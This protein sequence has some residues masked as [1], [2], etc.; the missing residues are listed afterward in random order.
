MMRLVV[1]DKGE[2]WPDVL[3]KAP[4][5]GSYLCMQAACL[6]KALQGNGNALRPLSRAFPNLRA[7]QPLAERLRQAIE[8][9]TTRHL[10][11]LLP[12][13]AIGRDA[14]MHR[15][16]QDTPLF[17]ILAEGAGNALVRQLHDALDKRRAAA[18][19]TR[20]IEG[21]PGELLARAGKREK[22]SVV[23]ADDCK[24][25]ERLQQFGIWAHRMK[26][27]G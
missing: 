4:G 1:D 15:M 9:Q 13:S 18:R 16:W 22:I 8:W 2:L 20:L 27:A 10:T 23:A 7:E 6:R 3:H 12:H 19:G 25:A 14:V 5:R 11:R 21:F 17:V 24:D 26:D